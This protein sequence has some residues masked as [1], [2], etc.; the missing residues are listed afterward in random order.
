MMAEQ[1]P[2]DT[3]KDMLFLLTSGW[4]NDAGE[5]VFCP[6]V[7]YLDGAL[8]MNP[9]WAEAITIVRVDPPRP[10][11]YITELLDEE[12]QNAPTLILA[13]DTQAH[14]AVETVNSR[15]FI[16]D[17]KAICVQLAAAYGGS[18]PSF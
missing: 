7:A 12:N 4:E 2:F 10:R 9:H 16:T 5:A 1:P 18:K 6:D 8:Q 15:R 11:P 3:G 17:P 14:E 13:G